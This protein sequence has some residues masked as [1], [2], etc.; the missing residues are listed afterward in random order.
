MARA[1]NIKPGFFRNEELVDLPYETRLLFIGLWTIADREGRL[2]DRPKRIKMELF[3]ADGLDVDTC[4][5]QLQDGGFIL[6]YEVGDARYIQVLAFSKHQN[7]HQKEQASIIPAPD[8]PSI[9]EFNT[10]DKPSASPVQE[11]DEHHASPADSLNTDSPFSDALIPPNPPEPAKPEGVDPPVL[12][13]DPPKP[14]GLQPFVLLE[15]LCE[16]LGQ[17]VSVLSASEKAKQLAV[18]QRLIVA[19]MTDGDVRSMTRWLTSWMTA[20]IDMFSLEKSLAKWKLAGKPDAT[21]THM[22]NG[23]ASPGNGK[24]ESIVLKRI[25]ERKRRE[26]E[27]GRTA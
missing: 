20:G 21:V 3:P 7:P 2:E 14:T 26:R 4:L 5:D 9:E 8:G 22:P 25:E 24:G 16:V 18:A 27:E 15:T 19:G 13:D 6:R 17:D 23:R 12:D 10:P 11:L 1:R